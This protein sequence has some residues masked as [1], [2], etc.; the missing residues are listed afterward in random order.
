MVNTYSK[1]TGQLSHI[2]FAGQYFIGLSVNVCLVKYENVCLS[3]N[4]NK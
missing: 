1:K 4:K 3:S 2:T